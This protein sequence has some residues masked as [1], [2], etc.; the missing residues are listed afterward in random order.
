MSYNW[1]GLM[2]LLN[3]KYRPTWTNPCGGADV[4]GNM[5]LDSGKYKP[6][7]DPYGIC[8]EKP[9]VMVNDNG[10]YYPRIVLNSETTCCPGTDCADCDDVLWD[11][12]ATPE[13]VQVVISGVTEAV[14]SEGND[15]NGTYVLDQM[16]DWPCWWYMEPDANDFLCYYFCSGGLPPGDSC[17]VFGTSTYWY[18]VGVTKP[19][20]NVDFLAAFSSEICC[21]VYYNHWYL[22]LKQHAGYG[23][24]AA[25]TWPV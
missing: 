5:E 11:N 15:P 3:G 10:K 21:G 12:G 17:V 18:F 13:K 6:V 1:D 24:Q 19:I 9:G 20:C 16:S 22:G 2:E 4:K 25:V 14:C 23:G 7:S 8:S